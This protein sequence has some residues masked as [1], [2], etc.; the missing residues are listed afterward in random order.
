MVIARTLS[1]N[2]VITPGDLWNKICSYKFGHSSAHKIS[3]D[4]K[5]H[6]QN[7]G[8]PAPNIVP[9]IIDPMPEPPLGSRI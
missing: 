1:S 4:M 2:I 8:P 9:Q 6:E 5:V 3:P 7:D